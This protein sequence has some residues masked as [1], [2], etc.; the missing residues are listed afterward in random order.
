MIIMKSLIVYLVKSL[1]NNL[2]RLDLSLESKVKIN[3]LPYK[4]LQSKP[5][6]N[7]IGL[8]L[9]LRKETKP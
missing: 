3:S 4:L 5:S 9:I 7:T 2:M 6:T 8:K 1:M